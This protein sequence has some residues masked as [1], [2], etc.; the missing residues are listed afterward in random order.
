MCFHIGS[1]RRDRSLS[2]PPRPVRRSRHFPEVSDPPSSSTRRH[3]KQPDPKVIRHHARHSTPLVFEGEPPSAQ[4]PRQRSR[5]QSDEPRGKR[6]S[7]RHPPSRLI[8][9]W[10]AGIPEDV[11]DVEDSDPPVATLTRRQGKQPESRLEDPVAEGETKEPEGQ[12]GK[13]LMESSAENKKAVENE[14]AKSSKTTVGMK[15]KQ[16]SKQ[17][18]DAKTTTEP[19]EKLLPGSSKAAG[20]TDAQKAAAAS[21]LPGVQSKASG[22]NEMNLPPE[23]DPPVS[24]TSTSAVPTPET[25][26]VSPGT[27]EHGNPSSVA[28]ASSGGNKEK[29]KK[30]R[31]KK[32]DDADAMSVSSLQKAKG[33]F[34]KKK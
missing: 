3:R 34:G 32:G 9:K 2:P 10:A 31:S 19:A 17:P 4:T 30:P 16:E 12:A 22:V 23:P 20:Q 21:K 5:K 1:S 15:K 7:R 33:I 25:E 8:R 13:P 24:T 6:R 14:K 28:A 18:M 27:A 11:E 29:G 26:K